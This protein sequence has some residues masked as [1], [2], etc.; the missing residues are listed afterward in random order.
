VNGT[1]A[2]RSSLIT[3]VPSGE[4]MRLFL[5][6]MMALPM[7]ET[8]VPKAVTASAMA[9]SAAVADPTG[10]S[11][12]ALPEPTYE[13]IDGLVLA[14]LERGKMPGCVV[15]LGRRRGIVYQKAFG[16]RQIKPEPEPMTDDTIFDL[17]SLTKPIVTATLIMVLFDQHRLDLDDPVARYLPEF[18][19][20]GKGA[21]TIRQVL[22]H[23]S[24]LPVETPF[25]DYQHGQPEAV[26]RLAALPLAAPPGTK[27][28]Y[29]DVGYMVL[30]E[31]VR[32]VAGADFAAFAHDTVFAPL[33]MNETE[34][35]PGPEL[36]PRI[37]PTELREGAIIR[38]EVHDPRAYR[39]GGVA[40]HAGLFS[41][42]RDL[43]RYARMMLSQGWFEGAR[44]LSAASVAKM[45]AAH[46]VPGGIRALGWD[47]QTRY[48]SNRGTS[49]SRRAFGHG[50][51]TGTSLWIDPEQDLFVIFLSNRVHPDGKGSVNGLA[52][53]IA[54]VAGRAR[55]P[56]AAAASAGASSDAGQ[57]GSRVTLGIDVL[58][59]GGFARLRGA[60]VALLTNEGA[61]TADGTRS[62]DVFA[63]AQALSLALLM[64][65]EHGLGADR[66]ESLG[67]SVDVR[68]KLRVYSLYGK[69]KA[70]TAQ[71]LSGIDTIVVDLP[72]AGARFYTYAST[73]HETMRVAAR[74]ALRVVVLDRPNPIN[75]T[76][77]AGPVLHSS[78]RSFVNH[79]P[80]AVRHGMTMGELAEMINADEHLGLALEVVRMQGYR[81]S[82]YF[83]ET[84]L[85][86]RP[87][88]PNLRTVEEAVLYPA[89]A[90]LE[91]TNVS[92]G[93][94]TATPFELLGA[95]FIEPEKLALALSSYH[96]AGISFSPVRFT[97][98]SSAH[99]G[100]E[101]GGVRLH[102]E[103]RSR[104]EPVRTGVALAL[105]L[106]GFYR[107][108]WDATRL[109]EM[110]GDP[111][112]TAAI[113]DLRPLGEIEGLWKDD[114]E[115]FRAK[116]A[117]YLLYP[118]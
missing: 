86:F 38:G 27:F 50:G 76:D 44:V 84:G 69:V 6:L 79:H 93:R 81:R 19:S 58:A 114:L 4:A 29:S 56:L 36:T 85:V 53:E 16:L 21:I 72:D 15:V 57:H 25:D 43:A 64:T 97:P 110:I 41:T 65:P 89:V 71:M 96:L 48:S 111:A 70:P 9:H 95:P 59:A 63:G 45:T 23:V 39:L 109:H 17:A 82:A 61:R 3:P 73:L 68:S 51:Y 90:L 104:F 30:E 78:E 67:D 98:K 35:L 1:I 105:A 62:V 60:R 28:I 113:L 116:R 10:V 46:D 18:S 115:A 24:G 42:A 12:S 11:S 87:P 14:A 26:R 34:F 37:A 54:T 80:L 118:P 102:V 31:V 13:A 99:A 40:G 55:A 33:G 75:A 32:R 94:G 101:C 107:D 5:L 7:G 83:D 92:V 49:L 88:S 91:G 66:D 52:G 8:V 74:L 77:V 112:V 2:G 103:D 20:A 106:R 22:T 47:V 108:Q 117:K 100:A